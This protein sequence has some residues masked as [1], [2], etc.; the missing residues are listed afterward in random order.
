MGEAQEMTTDVPILFVY[1]DSLALPRAQDGIAA[2]ETFA[3]QV[4]AGLT[5]ELAAPVA[6]YNRARGGVP[7][8]VL[9]KG[10]AEDATY[11]GP[12]STAIAIVEAGIVD[13]APRPIPPVARRAIGLL[14]T[15]IR[16][17]AVRVLHSQRSRLLNAGSVWRVTSP[18]R[19]ERTL[20]RWLQELAGVASR[21]YVLNIAPTTEAMEQHSPGL[22]RSIEQYNEIIARTT[23]NTGENVELVDVHS[24]VRAAPD[25]LAR[26]VNK[27]D[28]HHLTRDGHSMIAGLIL[29]RFTGRSR[30]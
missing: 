1:G 23:A 9:Y 27:V 24:A 21:V 16:Q 20:H 8:G 15:P 14:P 10:W 5:H 18:Q 3:E 2:P 11:F 22:S 25:G 6:L 28:G 26:Y 29:A 19:F 13:C 12:V 17:A 30:G 7:I 4:R